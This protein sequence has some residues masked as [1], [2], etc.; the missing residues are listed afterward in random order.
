MPETNEGHDCINVLFLSAAV[1]VCAGAPFTLACVVNA[2]KY[3]IICSSAT[4]NSAL[5]PPA[6]SAKVN[7]VGLLNRRESP[8]RDHIGMR[9]DLF[10]IKIICRMFGDMQI[11]TGAYKTS[12]KNEIKKQWNIANKAIFHCLRYLAG[13]YPSPMILRA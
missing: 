6:F 1:P 8:M 4:A 7:R 2:P 11:T 9:R 13:H 10:A 12:K 3:S 5:Q